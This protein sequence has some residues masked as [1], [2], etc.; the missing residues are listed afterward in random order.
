MIDKDK[1][2][3][4]DKAYRLANKEKIAARA[5]ARREAK[6]ANIEANEDAYPLTPSP[7]E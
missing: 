3:A 6:K 1:K 4:R 7:D 5:K 2:R